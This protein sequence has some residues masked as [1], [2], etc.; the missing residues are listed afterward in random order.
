MANII[1]MCWTGLDKRYFRKDQQLAR[2]FVHYSECLHHP[3]PFNATQIINPFLTSRIST[4][5]EKG[6]GF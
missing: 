3:L 4:N 2:P 5:H 6:K 1:S